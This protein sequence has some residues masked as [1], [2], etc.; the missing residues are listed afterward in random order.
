MT[1]SVNKR[2]AHRLVTLLIRTGT[3][4][5]VATIFWPYHI[6]M[7][8]YRIWGSH[9]GG[10]EELSIFWDITPSG[11]LKLHRRFGEFSTYFMLVS[12]LDYSLILRMEAECSISRAFGFYGN[13]IITDRQQLRHV[14]FLG[15][16]SAR[17]L[18]LIRIYIPLIKIGSWIVIRIGGGGR[19]EI[20]T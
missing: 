18:R 16:A 4:P 8:F 2:I 19:S 13:D 3:L 7:R 1:A 12:C 5:F 20:R 15:D 9:S 11:P 6:W 10:Y 17:L 14:T